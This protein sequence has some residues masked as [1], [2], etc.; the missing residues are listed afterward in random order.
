VTTEAARRR[1]LIT[2]D[3]PALAEMLRWLFSKEGFEVLHAID[4][5]SALALARQ[6]RP[7]LILSDVMLPKMDGFKFCRLVKFDADLKRIPFIFLT[8]R[9]QDKDRETAMQAGA[10]AY[11]TKPMQNQALIA[12]VRKRLG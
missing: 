3:D 9:T 7:D 2:E 4:G 8:A 6:E 1:I 12:E 10:D 11:L 5:I